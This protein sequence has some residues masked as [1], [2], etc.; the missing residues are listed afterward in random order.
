[1]FSFTR[2]SQDKNAR[3]LALSGHV[4][5]DSLPDQLVNKSTSQG[6][7]FNILCIGKNNDWKVQ[8]MCLNSLNWLTD[9]KIALKSRLIIFMV[10]DRLFLAW[11]INLQLIENNMQWS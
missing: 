5:F 10:S 1:M 7:C 3:P 11:N 9:A 4:G 6:F 2:I 8:E